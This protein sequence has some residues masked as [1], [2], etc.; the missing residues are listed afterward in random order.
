M[1]GD[2]MKFN[3][4]SIM[5]I[6]MI[7]LGVFTGAVILPLLMPSG[8]EAYKLPTA[9]EPHKLSGD[10]CVSYPFVYKSFKEAY[11]ECNVAI[12]DK[13]VRQWHYI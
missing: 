6:I 5:C 3:N 4:Y 2:L 8:Q 13:A 7:F 1:V 12:I 11:E 9:Q 10:I